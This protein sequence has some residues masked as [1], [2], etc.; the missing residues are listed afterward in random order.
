[1][2]VVEFQVR[3]IDQWPRPLTRDR[4]RAP[5]RADYGTTMQQL[6]RELRLIG[7][8]GIVLLM[9]YREQDIRLDGR[10]RASAKPDHP[11]VI[12]SFTNKTGPKRFPCDTFD[13][14]CANLRAIAL[15]LEALR[16]VDRYGVTSHGEQYR[17]WQALPPPNGDHW[18]KAQAHEWLERVLG[19]A[20]PT[21]QPQAAIEHLLREAEKKTHPDAGGNAADFHMV[22]QARKLLLG[23]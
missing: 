14:W 4:R 13:H 5:F 3:P 8:H 11:G 7:A 20:I 22:Q 21:G 18:T 9:A 16:K 23:N 6:D 12:V 10:P 1:M 19:T 15:S 17:G 2:N